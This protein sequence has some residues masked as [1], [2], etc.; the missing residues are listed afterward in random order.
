M[1]KFEYEINDG[2]ITHTD[3]MNQ[4]GRQGWELV[5][6]V[7]NDKMDGTYTMIWK[8]ELKDSSLPPQ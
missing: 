1:K 5:S 2:Q 8:R 7:P 3:I 6:V 4:R